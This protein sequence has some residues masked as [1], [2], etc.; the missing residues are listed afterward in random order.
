MSIYTEYMK[1]LCKFSAQIDAAKVSHDGFVQL[2]MLNDRILEGEH[3]KYYSW[4]QRRQL[5][6]IA[7]Y[8]I[9]EYRETIA[10]NERVAQLEKEIKKQRKKAVA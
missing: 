2:Q 5:Q 8:L 6:T 1:E 7:L 4:E 10:L 9:N 3:K